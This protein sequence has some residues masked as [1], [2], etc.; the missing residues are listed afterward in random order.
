MKTSFHTFK[1]PVLI[2]AGIGFLT[3][4]NACRSSPY[5]K[6]AL[7]NFE[8]DRYLGQWYEIARFDFKY[9]KDLKNVTA[10]YSRRDDGKIKVLNKGYN[11]V[12]QEWTQAEGKAKFAGSPSEAAL[13]VSFFGPFYAEY[14]VVMMQPDYEAALILGESKKYMWLL[15]R[16]KTLPE[17][18]KQAFLSFARAQGFPVE[19]LVWT[20]QD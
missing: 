3:L 15:S 7:K 11:Y 16:N 10:H 9:E 4:L 8:P 19:N 2:F 14:N 17:E 18:T 20:E 1:Y 6:L 12:K 5:Q 13:K